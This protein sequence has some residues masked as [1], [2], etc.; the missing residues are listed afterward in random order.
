MD[1]IFEAGGQHNTAIPDPEGKP[2]FDEG[3]NS[4]AIEFERESSR[5]TS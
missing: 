3:Q 2:A 1:S 4:I 5:L